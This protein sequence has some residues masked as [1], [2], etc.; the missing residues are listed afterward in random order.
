MYRLYST[1]KRG[2]TVTDNPY[3][4]KE[5]HEPSQLRSLTPDK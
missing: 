2:L 3:L 1:E 5:F 4:S